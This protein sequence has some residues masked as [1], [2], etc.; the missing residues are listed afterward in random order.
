MFGRS[1]T[2]KRSTTPL[3][4]VVRSTWMSSKKP[5]VPERAHVAREV[6][7]PEGLPGFLPQVGEDVVARDAP[8]PDDLDRRDGEAL[9][10]LGSREGQ[11]DEWTIRR[12]RRRD[13]RA[14]VGLRRASVGRGEAGR[15]WGSR[16]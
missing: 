7:G 8:V 15:G 6:L 13:G 5:G 2:M 3:S 9:G 1:R 16:V 4:F 11:I 12:A 10:L 14:R